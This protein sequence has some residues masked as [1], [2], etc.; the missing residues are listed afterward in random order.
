MAASGGFQPD[1]IA[2]DALDGV[3]ILGWTHANFVWMGLPAAGAQ[4]TALRV[5]HEL[6]I[7]GANSTSRP[8]SS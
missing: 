3:R 5:A 2:L 4:I 1:E 8:W 7:A 6:H